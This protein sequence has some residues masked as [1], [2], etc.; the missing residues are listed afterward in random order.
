M[1]ICLY[2]LPTHP[3]FEGHLYF[4]IENFRSNSDDRIQW[5]VLPESH[6]NTIGIFMPLERLAIDLVGPKGTE[7]A[8]DRPYS[9]R[10]ALKR[11]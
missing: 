11:A 5:K 8:A 7:F 9:C 10:G 2:A 1:R 3:K 4:S 6:P